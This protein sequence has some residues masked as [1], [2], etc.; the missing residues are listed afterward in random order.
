MSLSGWRTKPVI[1]KSS[2]TE[3]LNNVTLATSNSTGR[4][5][6][7]PNDIQAL[8]HVL[9]DPAGPQEMQRDVSKG[10]KAKLHLPTFNL[11]SSS[12]PSSPQASPLMQRANHFIAKSPSELNT[13]QSANLFQ[14]D[15]RKRSLSY[16]NFSNFYD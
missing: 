6:L 1:I 15:G 11:I 2:S 14:L 13:K 5:A 10:Q 4:K 9:S 8:R 16:S 3:N 7:S 12:T